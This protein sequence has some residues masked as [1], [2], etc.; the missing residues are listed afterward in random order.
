M[1]LFLA[2]IFILFISAAAYLFWPQKGKNTFVDNS[3]SINSK[4]EDQGKPVTE[5]VAEGLDTPWG[6][7]ILPAGEI[8][9]TERPGRVRLINPKSKLETK[10]VALIEKVK[11]I[12]EGGLLGIAVHPN[13]GSNKYVYL[14]YT[15]SGNGVN[16]LNRVVRMKFENNNLTGEQIIID[17]IPGNSNH[18]GGRIKFGPDGFLYITTGDAQNPSLAQNKE[19]L[20]GKILRVTDEGKPAPGNSFGTVIYSYGHRNPQGIAWDSVGRLWETEHGRSNPLS[21]LDEVNI[22][23]P[24]KNYGWPVIQGDEEKPGMVT[25]YANSG[26]SVTWAPAGA[27]F[28]RNKL[29]FGG[30]RGQSL[31]S[32]DISKKDRV[33]TEHLKNEFG[34]IRDIILGSDNMLY[35]TTSNNDGRGTPNVGDDKVIKINPE[36]L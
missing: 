32:I 7:A 13:F 3:G 8:L 30:L 2:V 28:V 22:I 25:P 27:V 36:K 31:Y 35:I 1:K 10:P 6:L 12:G 17:K 21:G 23:K 9:I 29:Y 26:A 33:V 34:R 11:E 20:A 15:Y 18:N 5:V 24:G 4:V 19:A 14:Y 16:T